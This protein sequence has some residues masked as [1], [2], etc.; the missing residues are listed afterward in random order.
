MLERAG[1]ITDLRQQTKVVLLPR[2]EGAPEIAWK[3]DFVYQQDGRA[4][5]EDAKQRKSGR[6]SSLTEILTPAERLL[7]KL[8]RHFG[9]GLLRITGWHDGRGYTIRTVMPMQDSDQL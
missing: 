9:P 1:N 7:V 2:S 8:W 6:L 4:V 3:V 5:W